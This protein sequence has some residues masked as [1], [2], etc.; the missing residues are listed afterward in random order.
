MDFRAAFGG[1]IYVR[2]SLLDGINTHEAHFYRLAAL[3]KQLDPKAVFVNTSSVAIDKSRTLAINDEQ[4]QNFVKYFGTN[5][6]IAAI[7]TT[8]FSLS[9]KELLSE[10]KTCTEHAINKRLFDIR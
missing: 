5:A 6:K 10:K 2:V 9:R 1:D 4:L 3:V 8:Y 7:D